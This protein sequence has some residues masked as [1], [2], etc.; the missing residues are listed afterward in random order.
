MAPDVAFPNIGIEIGT[1]NR[2]AF[3]LPIGDGLAIYW[4]GIF[5]VLGVSLGGIVAFRNTK[6]NG[7]T[8]Q[9]FLDFLLITVPLAFI[10]TRAYAVLFNLDL[11]RDNWVRIFDFR[12]GGMGVYGGIISAFVALFVFSKIKKINP[13]AIGDTGVFG[14][15]IGQILG[16]MGNFF[17]QEAFGGYTDN[18][19]AMQLRVDNIAARYS[20]RSL[21]WLRAIAPEN[22]R[23]PLSYELL[24][25]AYY[26]GDAVVVRVHPAFLYEMML[27]TAIFVF[28]WIYRGRKKFM[29]ELI[30]I[31]AAAYALGRFFIES[32]RTDQLFLWGTDIPI[33]M[34][35]S[36]I[37]FVCAVAL[38]VYFRR[39][40]R[41]GT[42]DA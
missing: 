13:G 7:I 4:Y 27:N 10:F 9:L 5:V 6:R 25:N 17:N 8:D 41:R 30:L 11:Y 3:T 24:Q 26:V 29:G 42:A 23:S 28:L 39:R 19:F 2:V 20:G 14:L 16:R 15:L 21:A 32:L 37:M 12:S 31:Y 34:L 38:I 33:S 36:A 35:V 1:L 22:V 40:A 18:I